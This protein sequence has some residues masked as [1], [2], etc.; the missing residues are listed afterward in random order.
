MLISALAE[1]VVGT[2][3]SDVHAQWTGETRRIGPV[4]VARRIDNEVGSAGK[5]VVD[6]ERA[7]GQSSQESAALKAFQRTNPGA[8]PFRL[9]LA[10]TALGR[11]KD[12][13]I[14]H[15]E[16]LSRCKFKMRFMTGWIRARH[17]VVFAGAFTSKGVSTEF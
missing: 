4:L 5:V 13:W 14:G 8:P 12:K 2:G 6:L 10:Q 1:S 15:N 7:A 11:I 17:R 3:G 16:V 9:V